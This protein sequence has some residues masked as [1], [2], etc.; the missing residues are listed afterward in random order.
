M[1]CNLP[2]VATDVGD[3]RELLEGTKGCH[4][5]EPDIE[6]FAKPLSE[7]LRDQERTQGRERIRH[8]DRPAVTQRVIQVYGEAIKR[9][10]SRCGGGGERYRLEN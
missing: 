8:L 1:A 10:K 9:R 2:I 7:I 6:A 4:I 5:C 3:V